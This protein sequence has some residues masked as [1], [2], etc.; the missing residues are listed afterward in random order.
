MRALMLW[1]MVALVGCVG[2]DPSSTPSAMIEHAWSLIDTR[3]ALFPDKSVDWQSVKAESLRQ[4]ESAGGD[5][6][7]EQALYTVLTD[8]LSTLEDAHINVITPFA[9]S[10]VP[11]WFEARAPQYDADLVHRHILGFEF[12]RIGAV[13]YGRL[14]DLGYLRIAHLESMPSAETIDLIFEGFS[15][16]DGLILDLRANGGGE[17]E[18]ANAW[19]GRFIDAAVAGWRIEIKNGPEHDALSDPELQ[20]VSPSGGRRYT[21]PLAVLVDGRT[22][23][24][25]NLL[26]F[27]FAERE[28]TVLVGER[29]GGGGGSTAWFELPNG[30]LMRLPVRRLTDRRGDSTEQGIEPDVQMSLDLEAVAQG[31]DSIIEAAMMV[32]E[33]YTE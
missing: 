26:A 5:A 13:E 18:I 2:G 7:D 1:L 14:G 27:N 32:L 6:A 4:L 11:A 15:D 8:M 12:S 21:G 16:V 10:W 19:L 33:R 20:G 31:R 24:G 22:Y 29:T 17:L 28:Q 23:S 9:V 3:Y 30:W 25:A